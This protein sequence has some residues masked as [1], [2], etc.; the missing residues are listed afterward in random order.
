M[1]NALVSTFVD[2]GHTSA[3]ISLRPSPFPRHPPPSSPSPPPPPLPVPSPSSTIRQTFFQRNHA[4]VEES[5]KPVRL[6]SVLQH[7]IMCMSIFCSLV[8]G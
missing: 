4:A 2:P 6:V 3:P 5:V 7:T 8:V 1:G